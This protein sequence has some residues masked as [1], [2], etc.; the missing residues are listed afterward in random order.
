LLELIEKDL[1]DD[2]GSKFSVSVGSR[3]KVGRPLAH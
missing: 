3:A 1:S 2:R